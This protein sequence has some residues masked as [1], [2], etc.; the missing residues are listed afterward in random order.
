MTVGLLVADLGNPYTPPLL[1]GVET[2]L[3]QAGYMCLITESRSY[4]ELPY[5]A[6]EQLLSRKVDG[7]II[8]AVRPRDRDQIKRWAAQIPVVLAVQALSRSAIPGVRTDDVR[9]AE[10]VADHLADLGHRNVAQIVGPQDV[11][12]FADRRGSFESRCAE[13]GLVVHTSDPVSEPTSSEAHSATA[14][15]LSERVPPFTA[16]FAHNDVMA[17]GVL[18]A[19]R[20]AGRRCP[21]EV[22]VVGYNDMPFADAFAPP[23]TTV[24]LPSFD[25]GTTAA[26]L[27]ISQMDNPARRPRSVTMPA[28]LIV[29]DSSGPAPTTT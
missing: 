6:V 29:R 28:E 7:L 16:V 4:H 22:S 26:E 17:I 25:I 19:L 18:S 9:G 10:L 15:L 2:R 23:L 12:S 3:D 14:T 13:R 1:K 21:D 27:L 24:R 5:A 20:E 11:R 8:E